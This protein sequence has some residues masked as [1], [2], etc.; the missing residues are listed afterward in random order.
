MKFEV[1][2]DEACTQISSRVKKSS[3]LGQKLKALITASG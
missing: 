1:D 2:W 3:K